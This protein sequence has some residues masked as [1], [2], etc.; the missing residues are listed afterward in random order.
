MSGISKWVKMTQNGSLLRPLFEPLYLKNAKESHCNISGTWPK[1]TP[2]MTQND[3]KWVTFGTPFWAIYIRDFL[4]FWVKNRGP[5][6][7]HFW[8][9]MTHFWVIFEPCFETI[10][11]TV[12][13]DFGSFYDPKLDPQNDPKWPKMTHFWPILGPIFEPIHGALSSDLG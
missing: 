9:K 10:H 6:M 8:P 13:H 4:W 5:K 7:T 12:A 1:M 11:A 2:K 3:P